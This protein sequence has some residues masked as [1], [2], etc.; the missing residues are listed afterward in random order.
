MD[1]MKDIT[2]QIKANQILV[3]L[4]LTVHTLEWGGFVFLKQ[5]TNKAY[6]NLKSQ[7]ADIEIIPTWLNSSRCYLIM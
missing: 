2:K 6:L 5:E 4:C 3:S 7:S 1:E